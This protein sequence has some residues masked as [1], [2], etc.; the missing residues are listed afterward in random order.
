M[1][2]ERSYWSEAHA[3]KSDKSGDQYFEQ[4]I[5]HNEE[6]YHAD[7]HDDVHGDIDFSSEEDLNDI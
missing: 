2:H 7:H 1:H 4:L 6:G 3:D 5:G